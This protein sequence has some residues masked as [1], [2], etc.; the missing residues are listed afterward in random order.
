MRDLLLRIAA[1]AGIGVREVEINPLIVGDE[2]AG[3]T[4]AGA[5]VVMEPR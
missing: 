1:L 5:L 3:T 2:G 4:A